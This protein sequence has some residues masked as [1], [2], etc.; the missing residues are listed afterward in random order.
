MRDVELFGIEA[1]VRM[2][3]MRGRGGGAERILYERIRGVVDDVIQITLDYKT[4]KPTNTTA[5][6]VFRDIVVRD[7]DM[8]STASAISC[9]GLDDSVITNIT[10]HNVTITGKLRQECQ[11]CQII[12][13]DVIPKLCTPTD[14]FD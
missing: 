3:S 14:G 11:D 9:L 4:T 8:N 5:T 10:V 12:Q 1:V 2:K 13:S 7:M 6:P